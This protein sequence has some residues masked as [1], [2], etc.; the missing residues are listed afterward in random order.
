MPYVGRCWRWQNSAAAAAKDGCAFAGTDSSPEC[1]VRRNAPRFVACIA[2]LA[3]DSA[4]LTGMQA[5]N[6]LFASAKAG[7]A[8]GSHC[9]QALDPIRRA[10]VPIPHT[11]LSS[12]GLRPKMASKARWDNAGHVPDIRA[13]WFCAFRSA[14]LPGRKGIIGNM[15][16]KRPW[17]S[18]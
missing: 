5:G 4:V 12:A 1:S 13:F 8:Q 6:G 18:R 14:G 11:A 9:I 3:K 15:G 2:L 7:Y 17:R 16:G 10:C